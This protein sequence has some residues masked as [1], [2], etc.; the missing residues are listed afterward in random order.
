[1][2]DGDIPPPNIARYQLSP[3][4]WISLTLSSATRKRALIQQAAVAPWEI[5]QRIAMHQRD[6]INIM[7]GAIRGSC[8]QGTQKKSSL[9]GG[10][11]CLSAWLLIPSEGNWYFWGNLE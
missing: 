1:M 3:F 9:K 2:T 4:A 11:V 7:I 5:T 8:Q 6:L 10:V